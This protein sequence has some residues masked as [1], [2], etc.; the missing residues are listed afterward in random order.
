MVRALFVGRFQPLHRGHEEV[1]KW[2]LSRHDELVIAIGSANES[3]TPRNPFTVGERIEMLVSMLR[4]LNL[5]EK[6]MYCAVP[7]TKGDSALWH[8][9]V[10]EQCPSFDIAY[11][12]D[13]F[14]KLCLEYGGIKVLNTPFFNKE[15]YSGTRIRELMAAGDKSW[16]GFVATGVLPVLSRINAEDRV[17]R[18]M[19]NKFKGSAS[20]IQRG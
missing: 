6:V 7:D 13:E 11:T 8:A 2:I 9:Y 3:F 4:E 1:I 19:Q 17:Q 12:N 5:I 14:T 18:I 16:Q 20:S 10:H 15:V